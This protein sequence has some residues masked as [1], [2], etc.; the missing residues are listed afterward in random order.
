M[1]KVVFLIN[2]LNNAGG[3]ERI[4]TSLA[5]YLADDSNIQVTIVAVYNNGTSFFEL[6]PS[7]TLHY[8]NNTK[9]GNIYTDYL[10]NIQRIRK[11]AKQ[12]QPNYWIDVCSAMSLMSL[13]ALI[14]L[15]IKVI[16]WEH[17]NAN[18]NWNPITSPLARK[19]ISKYAYKIVTLTNDDKHI[20]KKKYKAK[21]VICIPNFITVRVKG[22]ASLTEK[23][24][25]SIG[26]FTEQKGFDMLLDAWQL[27]TCRHEGWV[28]QIVGQ[29]ELKEALREQAQRLE[30][31][32]SVIFQE[33]TKNVISLYKNSSIY[34]MS[35]RFEGLPLVLIEAL[36]YGLP[37][38]SF[39]CE[40]GPKDIVEHE[41]TGILV[42]PNDIK[43]LATAID[44]LANTPD[45][46][47]EFQLNS[48][49]KAENFKVPYI[50][51]LWKDILK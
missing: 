8:L 31:T 47:K 46:R 51:G 29:G 28:L 30:L 14:G 33:P 45:K 10:R 40:T 39:N 34:V 17:F 26:R 48:I 9:H 18:V 19:L 16:S 49:R 22:V 35:S 7:I 32:D 27:T 44:F 12:I 25:L 37:I 4:T 1:P 24:I 36:S 38:I 3:T 15:H 2:S 20:F 11:L 5:N 13:P 43:Q 41:E 6:S 42:P 50:I 21:N 23:K